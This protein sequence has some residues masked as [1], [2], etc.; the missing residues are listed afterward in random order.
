MAP[1]TEPA[2]ATSAGQAGGLQTLG[3]QGDIH[4]GRAAAGLGPLAGTA[5]A[6]DRLAHLGHRR[7]PRALAN[8]SCLSRPIGVRPCAMSTRTGRSNRSRGCSGAC[9]PATG[10]YKVRRLA[11][12]DPWFPCTAAPAIGF[13]RQPSTCAVWPSRGFLDRTAR[14]RPATFVATVP[15]MSRASRLRLARPACG[16]VSCG[17]NRTHQVAC[18]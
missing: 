17:L 2:R 12:I 10:S 16:S 9:Q 5:R 6:L 11:A 15:G 13:L 14:P 8:G 7:L 18:W 4:G 3:K 1:Q